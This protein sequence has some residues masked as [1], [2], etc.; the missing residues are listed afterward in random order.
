[1]PEDLTP[2]A[3]E[4][5]KTFTQAE[6]DAVIGERLS[7]ERAKYADYE[8]L[9]EKALKFDEAEE[10]SKSELQ[11]AQ[12]RAQALQKELEEMK[13][14]AAVQSMR[15]AVS[16]ETGV[17]EDLLTGETEEACRAQAEKINNYAGGAGRAPRFEDRGEPTP[18]G[19]KKTTRD[20]F[21]EWAAQVMN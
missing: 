2:T 8:Q 4:P 14:A 12:E 11:K 21:G 3:Q 18:P 16:R 19:K 15:A 13:T 1:M 17:P 10:A 9:K 5:E 20:L 6:L 7:R